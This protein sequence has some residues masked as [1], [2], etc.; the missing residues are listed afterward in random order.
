MKLLELGLII[1]ISLI[2]IYI[3]IIKHKNELKLKQ[4]IEDYQNKETILLEELERMKWNLKIKE[5]SKKE[6]VKPSYK[7]NQKIKVLIADYNDLSARYTNAILENI[8]FI[9][10]VVPSGHDVINKI[11]TKDYDLI[12]V[13]NYF[14]NDTGEA[15]LNKVKA[16]RQYK[17]LSVP[18]FVLTVETDKSNYFLKECGFDGYLVKPIKTDELIKSLK[19]IYPELKFT[20]II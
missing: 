12:I 18:V 9:T 4:R 15:I 2:L 8:G 1:L 13:N 11:T 14:P 5:L 17:K 19:K 16:I 10:E 7:A 20:K 3:I 6:K